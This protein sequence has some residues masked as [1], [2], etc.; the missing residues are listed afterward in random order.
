MSLSD[1]WNIA[2]KHLQGQHDQNTHGRRAGGRV[3]L[4]DSPTEWQF[5]SYRV[6]QNSGIDP[7]DVYFS[8]EDL[9]PVPEGH[10]RIYHKTEL[11][12]VG[13]IR[14]N[15]LLPGRDTGRG[16]R[17]AHVLGVAEGTGG[18]FGGG[19]MY[20]VVDLPS[21]KFRFINRSWVE[22]G[23]VSPRR[24]T[25]YLADKLSADTS[26]MIQAMLEY[27]RLYGRS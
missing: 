13:S 8:P 15:G 3:G 14:E 2:Y 7:D 26:E 9:P 16:E 10:T 17:L 1:G 25:G 22:F 21:D 5:I 4:P 27:R 11:G 23:A 19:G 12:L 6:L 24:I 18:R 20:V